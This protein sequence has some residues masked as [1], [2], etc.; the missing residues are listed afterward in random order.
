MYMPTC[1]EHTVYHIMW[2]GKSACRI[3]LKFYHRESSW[4]NYSIHTHSRAGKK[5][6]WSVSESGGKAENS[7]SLRKMTP[8][9]V[10][11]E[12]QGQGQ[13][14]KSWLRSRNVAKLVSSRKEKTQSNSKPWILL[15]VQMSKQMGFPFRDSRKSRSP[16]N[17][18][19]RAQG[20]SW[21][22]SDF[23][24]SFIRP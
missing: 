10:G 14:V 19:V 16:A 7:W 8:T 3:T 24:W 6:D 5:V 11:F 15:T 17:T 23:N 21:Q 2:K 1:V 12:D 9:I 13:G 18:L 4:N 20:D 22:T